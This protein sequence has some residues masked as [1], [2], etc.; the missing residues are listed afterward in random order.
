MTDIRFGTADDPEKGFWIT[1]RDALVQLRYQCNLNETYYNIE[2][3]LGVRKQDQTPL[4][5]LGTKVVK[6][7]LYS[8]FGIGSSFCHIKRLPLEP[9]RYSIITEIKQNGIIV[10]YVQ[11]AASLDVMEG[12]YYGT[13]VI[14]PYG[15]FLCDYSWF[16]QAE[17]SN[18]SDE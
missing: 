1:G 12:D 13:G 9:G 14:W 2:I 6:Q 11:A 5:Y 7:D 10:D 15:G 4:L 8:V 18:P 3:A 17:D 16:H